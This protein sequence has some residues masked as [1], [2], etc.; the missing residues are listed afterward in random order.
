MDGWENFVQISNE[1]V[2][3]LMTA[4][5]HDGNDFTFEELTTAIMK[6]KKKKAPGPDGIVSEFLLEAGEGILLPLLDLFNEVKRSKIPPKQWN[7]VLITMIY[8][9]KIRAAVS[10]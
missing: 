8:C 9:I 6:M 5:V 10:R 4:E 2:E 7:S 1:L 3:I